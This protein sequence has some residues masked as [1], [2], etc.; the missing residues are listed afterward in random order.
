MKKMT[1][2]KKALSTLAACA[3]VFAC[4][5][6]A[7][8]AEDDVI[9]STYHYT[10]DYKGGDGAF[11]IASDKILPDDLTIVPGDVIAGD[12]TINNASA[13]DTEFFLKVAFHDEESTPAEND[14]WLT[15]ELEIT[16]DGA[17]TPL[18]SGTLKD[19]AGAEEASLGEVVKGDVIKFDYKVSVSTALN[20]VFANRTT[21]FDFI[22]FA[23]EHPEQIEPPAPAPEPVPTP[24]PPNNDAGLADELI[25]PEPAPP[26]VETLQQLVQT[27]DIIPYAAAAAAGVA[28]VVGIVVIVRRKRN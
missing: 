19:L 3:L 22:V 4:T 6:A 8:F 5:P 24:E 25:E 11:D 28:I 17:D 16:A 13:N 23:E 7:A 26:L 9:D 20:N 15:A 18:F 12:F 2:T 14:P 1:F 27:G 21:E 10:A